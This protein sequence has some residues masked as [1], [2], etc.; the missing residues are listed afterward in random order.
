MQ[1]LGKKK[2]AEAG[3]LVSVE[4]VSHAKGS[5]T[6]Q[7][8]SSRHVAAAASSA[9]FSSPDTVCQVITFFLAKTV[10]SS[11]SL[12]KARDIENCRKL[13]RLFVYQ[14]AG[15]GHVLCSDVL[16]HHRVDLLEIA[17]PQLLASLRGIHA[18]C[19]HFA[20]VLDSCGKC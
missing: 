16:Q 20:L 18:T 13:L 11:R 4:N 9:A 14:W 17:Q 6:S 8:F 2:S 3:R 7:K 10:E 12:F 1:C 19:H 15:P 5:T